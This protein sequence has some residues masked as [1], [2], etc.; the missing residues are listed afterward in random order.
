MPQLLSILSIFFAGISRVLELPL[1]VTSQ[2]SAQELR[3]SSWD[4]P[5]WEDLHHGNQQML[6]NEL[7]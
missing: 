5:S 7:F 2:L 3:I 6:Q 1:A 4:L